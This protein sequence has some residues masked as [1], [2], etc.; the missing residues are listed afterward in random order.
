M[1]RPYL[2][3]CFATQAMAADLEAAKQ[4]SA[5][6]EAERT[7]N[8]HSSAR[9]STRVQ[10]MEVQL[11]VVHRKLNAAVGLTAAFSFLW[12]SASC[13]SIFCTRV[14]NRALEC[15]FL[16]RSASS[17]ADV[18]LAASRSAAIACVAKH[19]RR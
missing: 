4:T 16:V 17:L 9:L 3:P 10:E 13:T 12:M 1:S 2:L 8:A 5:K 18:C 11:A 15:A 6:L 19:G 7:K 14:D